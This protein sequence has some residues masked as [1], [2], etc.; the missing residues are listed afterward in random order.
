[1]AYGSA[2]SASLT[3]EC[4]QCPDDLAELASLAHCKDYLGIISASRVYVEICPLVLADCLY[5]LPRLEHK[6]ECRLSSDC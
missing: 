2:L 6:R 5:L 4:S 3:G 1:M